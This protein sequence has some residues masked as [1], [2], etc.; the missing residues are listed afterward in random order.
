M[1]PGSVGLFLLLIHTGD[2]NVTL[3]P[4]LERRVLMVQEVTCLT[5]NGRGRLTDVEIFVAVPRSNERQEVH[6]LTYTRVPDRIIRDPFGN[7]FAVF[8]SVNV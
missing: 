5:A 7:A 8:R 6:S 3:G 1:I 4:Q 2:P